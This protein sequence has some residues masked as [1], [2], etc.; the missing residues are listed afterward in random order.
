MNALELIDVHKRFGDHVALRGLNLQVEAGRIVCL[1]G[2][3]GSGKTTL[4]RIVAGL[5]D[6]DGGTVRIGGHTVA[7]PGLAAS[8]PERRGLGMVF[9]DYALWPHLSALDNVALPL[10]A[11]RQPRAAEQALDMLRRVGLEAMRERR[12]HE[13]SGGQQQRVALARALAVRPRLLLCDEPLSNLDAA[14]REELRD[15]I[16]GVVREHGL[17]ALYITHDHREA[18]AL[19]DQVGILDAGVLRQ[20]DAP[21][22]LLA[23]PCDE[24]VARFV[25]APGPWP[26]R[27]LRGALHAPWGPLPLGSRVAVPG[28]NACL[29]LPAAA[30]R[31]ADGPAR[32]GECPV[33]AEVLRCVATPR[34]SELQAALHGVALRVI[35]PAWCAPGDPVELYL[36]LRRA[37]I[38]ERCE[39][40]AQA[41]ASITE[42]ELELE[43]ENT[44]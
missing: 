34:G 41:R 23:A 39:A 1:L 35:G 7:G 8:P 15:L 6:P 44:T 30:V 2:A 22:A 21:R 13:L 32:D 16:G 36:D 20:M 26:L 12:P 11:R 38:Y 3:S 33:A 29:Y 28:D 5:E 37:L 43:R 19:G 9:Q 27:R 31:V 17:S 25:H 4:L 14:L 18:F 40:S 10:R 42:S 24:Q